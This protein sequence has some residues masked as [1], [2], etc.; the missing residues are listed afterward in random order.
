[1]LTAA[2]SADPLFLHG[3]RVVEL[4]PP[5]GQERV[6]EKFESYLLNGELHIMYENR[7]TSG[8]WGTGIRIYKIER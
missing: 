6:I 1:M 3:D 2:L 8:E 5:L 7:L 4:E